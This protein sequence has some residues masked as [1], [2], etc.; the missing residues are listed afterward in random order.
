VEGA[1]LLLATA[2]TACGLGGG[3]EWVTPR[4]SSASATRPVILYGVDPGAAS[5]A[6]DSCER[7]G[8]VRAWSQG[9]KTFPYGDMREAA[10]EAGGDGVTRIR[11]DPANAD[12][13]RSV[14]LGEVV[15]CER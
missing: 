14:H 4:P 3:H 1:A 10:A 15:R 11:P 9:E 6:R 5:E 8:T 12:R 7:L 13:R 2:A